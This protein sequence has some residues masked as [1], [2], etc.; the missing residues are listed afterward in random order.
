MDDSGRAPLPPSTTFIVTVQDAYLER[1]QEV[2]H[3]LEEAGL[4][5]DRVLGSL[6]QV[7][8]HAEDSGRARLAGVRGVASIEP[9][10]RF[11]I[12]PPESGLQ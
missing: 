8:G 3:D 5:I 11:G 9:E 7:V 12:A 2:A 6:G 1:V 4:A 10:R